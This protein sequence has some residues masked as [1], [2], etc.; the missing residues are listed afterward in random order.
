MKSIKFAIAL[1]CVIGILVLGGCKEAAGTLLEEGEKYS[2]EAEKILSTAQTL[3]G[4][5]PVENGYLLYAV[6]IS[7]FI[8][9]DFTPSEWKVD[10]AAPTVMETGRYVKGND[11]YSIRSDRDIYKNGELVEV[12]FPESLFPRG[13]W[14]IE[15]GCYLVSDRIDGEGVVVGAALSAWEKDKPGK[16]MKLEGIPGEIRILTTGGGYGYALC[17]DTVYRTDGKQLDDLGSLYDCGIDPTEAVSML[18]EENGRLLLVTNHN[19][20]ELRIGPAKNEEIPVLTIASYRAPSLSLTRQVNDF[21]LQNNGIRAEVKQYQDRSELNLAILAG[22]VDIVAGDNAG[23]LENYARKGFLQELDDL[24]AVELTQGDL[25]ENAVD[26]GRVEG[27]LYYLPAYF[28]VLGMLL[29]SGLV[30]EEGV[31]NSMQDLVHMLGK[32]D[33]SNYLK[34]QCKEYALNNFLAHGTSAW[35]DRKNNTCDFEDD[36]DFLAM[37]EFCN[38][39]ANDPDEVLAY[40]HTESG[41]KM[42]FVPYYTVSGVYGLDFG[43]VFADDLTG[44]SLTEYGTEG[45]LVPC[46]VGEGTGLTIMPDSLYGIVKTSENTEIAA[47]WMRFVLDEETYRAEREWLFET[48][49][50]FPLRKSMVEEMVIAS[51]EGYDA[52]DREEL[53]GQ[54]RDSARSLLGAADH[55]FSGGVDDTSDIIREEALRYFAGDI[56]ATQAAEY[57]QNRISIYL[58]EQS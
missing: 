1:L 7:C 57:V 54:Y 41:E 25:F 10:G 35:V 21:N 29:P 15:N 9:D 33:A 53:I 26:A 45:R 48:P 58:A 18:V 16:S 30:A 3:T 52:E 2:L 20:W 11:V 49:I 8:Q 37:L 56:T 14:E 36:P 44:D 39:F 46:P 6:G 43:T 4:L 13:F 40:Y 17:E 22:N 34:L 12:S 19:L 24:L 50:G 32:L 42:E 31:S 47:E 23:L 38:R 51:F 5:Q 28:K 27:T 55:H